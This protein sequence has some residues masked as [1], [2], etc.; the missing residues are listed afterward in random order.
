MK[1]VQNRVGFQPNEIREETDD[2]I[3]IVENV[4]D[5]R[6][7]SAILIGIFALLFQIPFLNNINS[8]GVFGIISIF[9]LIAGVYIPYSVPLTFENL[10]LSV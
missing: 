4:S 9:F 3:T 1:R 10:N 5:S 2:R 6:K 7:I 8:F